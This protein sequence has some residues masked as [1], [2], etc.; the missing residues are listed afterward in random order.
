M[1]P[2]RFEGRDIDPAPLAEPLLLPFSRRVAPNRFM[3]AAMSERLATWDKDD[4]YNSGLPTK[5]LM[6]LYRHWCQGGWG[7]VVTGN[8]LIDA[9]HIEAPGNMIITSDSPFS[10][11]RFEA[12]QKLAASAKADSEGNRNAALF[13]G[14]LNHP[15]R[16]VSAEIQTD[17]ISASD[18]QLTKE[19]VGMTF[20]KPHA[21]SH[22]EIRA[23][24]AAFAHAAAY[25]ER[26]GFDGA[27]LHGAHGYLIAQF[28]S[29]STN[30][31]TDAYGGAA[32]EDRA[33]L[34]TEIADAVRAATGPGFVLGIKINSVEFEASGAFGPADAARL[35]EL[36]ERHGFDLVELSGGTYEVPAWHHRGES[37]RRR[38]A[39]FLEF[40]ELVVPHVQRT[41]CFITGGLQTVGAMVDAVRR[42]GLDGVGLARASATEPRFPRDVLSGGVKACI[43]PLCSGESEDLGTRAVLSAGQMRLIS[44]D[45]EPI[46]P[47]D[48]ESFDGFLKDCAAWVAGLGS[49]KKREVYGHVLIQSV[50]TVPYGSTKPDLD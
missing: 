8:I 25:L 41:R 28:L 37:T 32:L 11:P 6:T 23:L 42:S 30:R 16:Q 50:K 49:R 20:A 44:L 27:H 17:P 35:V 10:G 1:S 15:G 29:L 18:V 5:E 12:F 13:L 40:A 43:R 24:V 36:L 26:A 2:I 34:V 31:R 21:A 46:D 9:A 33:R 3:K 47:S 4:M 48:Q 19:Y 14:Q 7:V 38:E 22:A 45:R 39:F